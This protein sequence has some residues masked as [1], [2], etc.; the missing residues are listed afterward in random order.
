M[1]AYKIG[2]VIQLEKQVAN[3]IWLKLFL[4]KAH[5][6]KISRGRENRS[7]LLILAI[8]I[9]GLYVMMK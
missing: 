2:K 3:V 8:S 4:N 7:I 5:K 9:I 1:I 6:F